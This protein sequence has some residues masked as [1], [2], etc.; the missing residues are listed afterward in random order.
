MDTV[1]LI[2]AGRHPVSHAPVLP[3]LEAQM[4]RLAE[5]LGPMR[6]LHAGPDVVPARDSLGH[7]L[8]RLDHI[9][10]DAE[11][12]PLPELVAHLADSRPDL[13][14]AGR[15]GEGGEE[16]GLVPYVIAQRLG[17][18]LIPD[19]IALRPGPV[20][21]SVEVEQALAKGA[22]RRLVVR[23]PL[24]ATVHPA[25][26]VPKPFAYA[27]M[28]RGQVNVLERAGDPPAQMSAAEASSVV[29]R[30]FKPR[31]KLMRGAPAGA[32]ASERLLAATGGSEGGGANVLVD[33]APE[34]AARAILAY[35]RQ[36]GAV[37]DPHAN[38]DKT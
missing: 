15:R 36:I 27:Q 35:L 6:G 28:R 21:Q 18:T 14:L 3:R 20:P 26:P 1:L 37:P 34:V 5:G 7:G 31:P 29:T 4:I 10:I 17:Y 23:L 9:R 12:D 19:I 11:L 38:R 25:A 16:T 2:S 30:P 24:V 13:I 33:P 22:R 8:A 32:S